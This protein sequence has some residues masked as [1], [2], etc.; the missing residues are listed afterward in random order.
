MPLTQPT[1][2]EREDIEKRFTYHSPKGDQPERYIAV[3]NAAKN[4]AMVL[5]ENVPAGRERS[6]ALT[7]LEL[8]TFMANAGIAREQ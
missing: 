8:A 1:A 5:I 4:L 6:A 2:A 7:Q 3:R